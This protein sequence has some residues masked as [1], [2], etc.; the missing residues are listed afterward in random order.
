MNSAIAVTL[1]MRTTFL[2]LLITLALAGHASAQGRIVA[3][4]SNLR[5][6]RGVSRVCLFN[7]AEDFKASRAL[8]CRVI[9][10]TATEAVFE[11]I[12]PGTYAVFVIHDEN[13]NNRMDKNFFGIP[14]EGY[15]AS[16]NNLPF[17]AAPTFAG[18][19]FSVADRTTV[20]L[21]IRLRNL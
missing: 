12:T 5:N 13:N 9:P 16:R 11:G 15:G 19:R 8:Q 17:A 2:C 20:T 3:R 7:T 1:R 10:A 21:S 14:K 18:N 6:G 4:L